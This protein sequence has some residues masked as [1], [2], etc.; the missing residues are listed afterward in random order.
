M[1]RKKLEFA[2]TLIIH[3]MTA[4]VSPLLAIAVL[5]SKNKLTQ[6]FMD[7]NTFINAVFPVVIAEFLTVFMTMYDGRYSFRRRSFA[8][9]AASSA[10][11]TVLTAGILAII[12]LIQKNEISLSR[13]YF[14]STICIHLAVLSVT[15]YIAQYY[16]INRFYRSDSASIVLLAADKAYAADASKLIKQ[17]WSRKISAVAILDENPCRDNV[18]EVDHVP[19]VAGR[20]DLVEWVQHH[21]V[22]EVFFCTGNNTA[23]PIIKAV[24][25]FVKMGI[26][27]HINLTSVSIFNKVIEKA[28]SEYYPYIRKTLDTFMNKIPIVSYDPPQPKLRYLMIKRATDICFGLIGCMITLVLYVILGIVIKLDSPGPVL[29]AQERV[30]RNGRLFRI[31]K[32]RSMYTDAEE[33]KKALM[34]DNE[35]NG[36]MFKMKDD[37]RITPVGRF[38]RRTS[39][40][41]FPQFFNVLMGDMSLVGTRP[42]TVSEFNHYSDYHKRRL[43]MKPGI[44]GMWQVSG[45]SEIKDF[46][47]V[48]RLDCRYIDNWSIWLDIKIIIKTFAVVL[49]GKGSE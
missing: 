16:I 48:V 31:Y 12:L 15:Y 9:V 47:D 49:T 8:A 3:L 46:E 17:D 22:D 13:Y 40:D 2:I 29:F 23:E 44:T 19:V 5:L 14:V 33:R 25:A 1:K 7:G 24:Q 11:K 18:S 34:K 38:I 26:S 28:D 35:M 32:F 41:E 43:A 37:P 36:L 21:A 10:V 45:R 6:E 27:V 39:L 42:P 20:D 4:V 30:G